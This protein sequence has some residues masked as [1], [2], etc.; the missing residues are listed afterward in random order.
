M[1]NLED[2]QCRSDSKPQMQYKLCRKIA[3]GNEPLQRR[4]CEEPFLG[5]FGQSFV[6]DLLCA[7]IRDRLPFGNTLKPIWTLV[8]AILL[9]LILEDCLTIPGP[10]SY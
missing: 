3:L 10:L 8:V 4:F 2:G 9:I 1:D 6:F 5:N 7:A